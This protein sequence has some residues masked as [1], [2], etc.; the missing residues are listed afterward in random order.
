M[1]K[2]Y[3][4]GIAWGAMKQQLFEYIND[5]I[6]PARDEY[7]RLMADPAIVEAELQKGAVRAREVSAPYMDQIRSAIGIRK[8]G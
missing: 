8:L 6:G 2:Q 7:D 4:E 1:A 5:H 3:E